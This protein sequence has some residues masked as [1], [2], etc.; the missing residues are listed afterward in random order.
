[1]RFK[2]PCDHEHDTSEFT[3]LVSECPRGSED[4]PSLSLDGSFHPQKR[5]RYSPSKCEVEEE[6][7]DDEGQQGKSHGMFP[8]LCLTMA[9]ISRTISCACRS[10]FHAVRGILECSDTLD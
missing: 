9:L 1:M 10:D 5:A 8:V 3:L 7:V 4:A 6:P 2:Q